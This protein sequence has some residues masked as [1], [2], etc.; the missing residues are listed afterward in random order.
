VS[1]VIGLFGRMRAAMDIVY[2]EMLKFGAVGALAFVVDLYVY[3]LLR[4]GV[5]PLEDA[6]FGDKPLLCKVISVTCATIVAWLGN[7][8]WTF[9][10]RR[11]A[12]ARREFVLFA[13]MNIG[14]LI[15]SLS[16][17]GFSHYV[18]GLTSALADNISGNMIGIALGT[19]FRFWAYRQFVFTELQREITVGHG[20]DG[21]DDQPA[22][23]LDE[24]AASG[25][26]PGL[27]SGLQ[28]NID[29]PATDTGLSRVTPRPA[30]VIEP[31]RIA[32]AHSA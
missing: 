23:V 14:G 9:R 32:E 8:L 6:P 31:A 7:R 11:R 26:E 10:H 21:H 5:W 28:S 19:L 17:L 15:I 29:Q 30:P 4:V 2:R 24:P 12:A 20:P 22:D 18:L 3:N 13:V 25:L 27:Q 1:E 16:C